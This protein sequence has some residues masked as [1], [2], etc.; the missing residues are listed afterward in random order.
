MVVSVIWLVGDLQANGHVPLANTPMIN[1]KAFGVWMRV[2]MGMCGMFSL[3]AL[4]SYGLYRVFYLFRP[5]HSLG[6]YLPFAV[7]WFCALIVGVVSQALKP[8]YTVYYDS[9]LD[10]CKYHKAF[11]AILYAFLWI[12]LFI[13][14]IIHWEIRHIKSSFNES[15]EMLVTSTIM[16]LVLIYMTNLHYMRPNYPLTGHLRIANTSVQHLMFNIMWW[17]IMG[18]PLYKCMFDQEQYLKQWIGK[19]RK[20]GLQK[21]YKVD[22]N[23]LAANGQESLLKTS[24]AGDKNIPSFYPIDNSIYEG[25]PGN[26]PNKKHV[27]F[28]QPSK[29]SMSSHGRSSYERVTRL[30]LPVDRHQEDILPVNTNGYV[31]PLV[32]PQLYMPVS[33]PENAAMAPL[34]LSTAHNRYLDN[35]SLSNRHLL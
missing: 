4:R 23:A 32:G 3:I 15:R 30:S 6:L 33:V 20:D 5:Y 2:L 29:I 21:E 11:Q 25:K 28:S 12:S 13:V 14:V 9:A 27:S 26:A 17:L 24:S 34:K 10:I 22:S 8:A 1:C 31:V 35:Y 7:Y 19:L 16:T 18:V